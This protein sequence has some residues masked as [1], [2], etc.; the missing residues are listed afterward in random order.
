M[1]I[2]SCAAGGSIRYQRCSTVSIPLIWGQDY[3]HRVPGAAD[4]Q[5]SCV[6]LDPWWQSRL[7]IGLQA[8]GHHLHG[9]P[10]GGDTHPAAEQ[11]QDVGQAPAT[12]T[13]HIWIGSATRSRKVGGRGREVT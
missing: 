1:W 4:G 3:G 5:W 12:D 2:I 11:G 8:E 10:Q 9:A 6:H 13:A 7:L